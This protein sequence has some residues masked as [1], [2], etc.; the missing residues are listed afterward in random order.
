MTLSYSKGDIVF[1]CDSCPEAVDTGTSSFEAAR[2]FLYRAGWK[3]Y[4]AGD[5]WRH[6]CDNCLEKPRKRQDVHE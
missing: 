2:N 4:K 3:T 5:V 6:R 1:S